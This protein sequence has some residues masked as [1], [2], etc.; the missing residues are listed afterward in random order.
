MKWD[1]TNYTACNAHVALPL[2]KYIRWR[3]KKN[4]R[5]F[6]MQHVQIGQSGRQGHSEERLFA[7]REVH[8]M[9]QSP[10]VR[11]P[12]WSGGHSCIRPVVQAVPWPMS[13]H[14]PEAWHTRAV[15]VPGCSFLFHLLQ[16]DPAAYQTRDP[17]SHPWAWPPQPSATLR[18]G[19]LMEGAQGPWALSLHC[20]VIAWGSVSA[21]VTIR[22]HCQLGMSWELLGSA[23][24]AF[25]SAGP[26]L[27]FLAL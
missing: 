22:Y 10:Q 25:P 11:P 26:F 2:Q 5:A 21:S 14:Q 19:S 4:H 24:L 17:L 18:Q 16:E 13:P 15:A 9:E 23:Y 8:N 3:A 6:Q 12:S 7:A 27:H 1:H 20:P